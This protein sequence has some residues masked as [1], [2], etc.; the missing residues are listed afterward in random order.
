MI[1]EFIGASALGEFDFWAGGA[2][3]LD[4]TCHGCGLSLVI[5]SCDEED[6]VGGDLSVWRGN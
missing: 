3:H 2:F 1:E 6:V 4:F 5:L